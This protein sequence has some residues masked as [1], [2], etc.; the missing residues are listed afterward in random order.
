MVALTASFDQKFPCCIS[1]LFHE[2][3]WFWLA[4]C[5]CSISIL[6]EKIQQWL[7]NLV[8]F[9][10]ANTVNISVSKPPS[11]LVKPSHCVAIYDALTNHNPNTSQAAHASPSHTTTNCTTC[12]TAR[13]GRTC[14]LQNRSFFVFG[15]EQS[16][17]ALCRSRYLLGPR[18]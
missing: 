8:A 12:F 18:V 6:L 7:I 2:L 14:H 4:C 10:M 9:C 16:F 3:S 13:V 15:H 11:Q 1:D 17:Q 5:S